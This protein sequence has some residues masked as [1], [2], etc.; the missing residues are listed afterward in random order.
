[1]SDTNDLID[2]I[3]A[4]LGTALGEIYQ[5]LMIVINDISRFP[6]TP[7]NRIEPLLIFV[8][9]EFNQMQTEARG[10]NHGP[11]E[12]GGGH[13]SGRFHERQRGPIE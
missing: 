1:M 10:I 8:W 4:S 2:F 3:S 13:T 5:R 11:T 9:N 6:V 7:E 12:S